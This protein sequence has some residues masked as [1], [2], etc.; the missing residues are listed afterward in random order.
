LAKDLS[1]CKNNFFPN[2]F[3]KHSCICCPSFLIISLQFVSSI[4]C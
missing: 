1:I 4:L 3:Y 2:Q